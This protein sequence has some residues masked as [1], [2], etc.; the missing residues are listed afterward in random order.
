MPAKVQPDLPPVLTTLSSLRAQVAAWRKAGDTIALVPTMGALHK[1]HISLVERATKHKPKATVRVVVSIFVN[2]AQFAPTEDFARYPRDLDA[3]RAKLAD[4]EVAAILAPTVDVMYP[5]GHS[6]M[7]EP[8]TA[9]DGLETAF[10]PHFF[11]GVTTVCCKLF[12]QVTPDFAIFGEKDY[13]QLCVIRQMVRDLDM[14]LDIVGAPT[15]RDT[16]NL[17]LS[18]RNR[19]L[20]SDERH[21]AVALP[22]ALYLVGQAVHKDS[23]PASIDRAVTVARAFL[24]TQGFT[25]VDYVA[26]RD[27]ETLG[28]YTPGKPGRILGAAWMGKTR[29]I[30]NRP[31]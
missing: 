27:A 7:V 4:A 22:Q 3:D 13:Q 11:K 15:V 1:G 16:D 29:L 6:V 5:A 20:S 28:A 23:K 18:S 25:S 19:Y 31:L 30:D 8:G 14:S 9:A 24:E 10:R 12:N 26:V 17:A 2:P 21:K